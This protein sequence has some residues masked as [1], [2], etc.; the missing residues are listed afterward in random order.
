MRLGSESLR[1]HADDLGGSEVGSATGPQPQLSRGH[2]RSPRCRFRRPRLRGRCSVT[3]FTN[4]TDRERVWARSQTV[5][6]SVRQ[7]E[8]RAFNFFACAPEGEMSHASVPAAIALSA[9]FPVG[10]CSN[11]P[12]R[13]H[14]SRRRERD[15]G[16]GRAPVLGL[17]GRPP[18][19]RVAP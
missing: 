3:P 12:G 4:L 1:G 19:P 9:P 18:R 15:T 17:H 10:P 11:G 8:P 16:P 6:P 5:L 7:T 13:D 2:L 14:L